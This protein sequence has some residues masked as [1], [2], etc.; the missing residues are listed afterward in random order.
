MCARAAERGREPGRSTAA[1]LGRK[2]EK[3][4]AEAPRFAVLRTELIRCGERPYFFAALRR[5]RRFF[6]AAFF[7]AFFGAFLALRRRLAMCGFSFVAWYYLRF[8][9][10]SALS[11]ELALNFIAIDAGTCTGAPV[12]GFLPVRALR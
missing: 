6:G 4:G 5:R 2:N 1:T 9:F 11:V 12:W 3:R 7:A 8:G 10:R